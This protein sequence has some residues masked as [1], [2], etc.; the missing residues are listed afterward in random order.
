MKYSNLK[1][2]GLLTTLFAVSCAPLSRTI[3][4]D[5]SDASI[6][7]QAILQAQANKDFKQVDKFTVEYNLE[8]WFAKNNKLEYEHDYSQITGNKDSKSIEYLYMFG[9]TYTYF[10]QLFDGNNTMTSFFKATDGETFRYVYDRETFDEFDYDKY[11]QDAF[12]SNPLSVGFLGDNLLNYVSGNITK[13]QL[14]KRYTDDTVFDTVQLNEKYSVI[15]DDGVLICNLNGTASKEV[16][17]EFDVEGSFSL[18][19]EY[20]YNLIKSSNFKFKHVKTHNE[21]VESKE[22]NMTSTI[23][24]ESNFLYDT[25]KESDYEYTPH[26]SSSSFWIKYL[27]MTIGLVK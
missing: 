5:K 10:Y 12:S 3:E 20:Q 4:I 6:L 11:F 9:N 2:I 1:I 7:A 19:N 23:T 8:K 24:Y 26:Y 16:G 15:E 27:Y 17:Q 13:E 21:Y 22:G 25:P 14:I 18:K